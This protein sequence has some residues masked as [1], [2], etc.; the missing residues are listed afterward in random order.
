[1]RDKRK[2]LETTE[3]STAK[4]VDDARRA[5]IVEAGR[6]VKGQIDDLNKKLREAETKRNAEV[7][8]AKREAAEDAREKEQLRHTVE[9]SRL[10]S[11]V[12]DLNRQLE[13]KSG[14]QFGEEGELNLYAELVRSF[15]SDEHSL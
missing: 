11:K 10:Q 12:D 1:L 7:A 5:G 6:M 4:Q 15:P 2:K 9:T 3:R 14:E 13:K 8:K